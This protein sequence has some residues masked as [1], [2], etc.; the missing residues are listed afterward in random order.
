MTESALK[1]MLGGKVGA[2]KRPEIVVITVIGVSDRE[3][4]LHTPNK[5]GTIRTLGCS[6]ARA[7]GI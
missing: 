7:Q 3:V 2:L 1:G 4:G 6:F 5:D